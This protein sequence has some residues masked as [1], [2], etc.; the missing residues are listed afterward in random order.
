M[1]IPN[2]RPA[3]V[4]L[5]V[6][7]RPPTKDLVDGHAATRD[8]TQSKAGEELILLG[9]AAYLLVTGSLT[10]AVFQRCVLELGVPFALPTADPTPPPAPP[11]PKKTPTSRR[12][13]RSHRSK[14]SHGPL[15]SP[16]PGP[17]T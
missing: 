5:N 7:V 15:F 9:H 14:A 2:T 10:L 16:P 13:R 6:K 3:K 17:P 11:E 12:A 8:Q 4:S 1:A